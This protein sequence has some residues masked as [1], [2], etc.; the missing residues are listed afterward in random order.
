MVSIN[1]VAKGSTVKEINR[2]VNVSAAIGGSGVDV[3]GKSGVVDGKSRLASQRV[4]DV[5]IAL[6][7]EVFLGD[8]VDR[9][10]GGFKFL[11]TR[12]H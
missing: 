9:C 5:A 12:H 3:C 1:V 2:L 8:V 7:F 11:L 6:F 10:G 4:G